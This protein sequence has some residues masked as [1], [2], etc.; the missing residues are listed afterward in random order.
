LNN[1]EPI[2]SQQDFSNNLPQAIPIKSKLYQE[3][4]F[5][6]PVI[7]FS[8]LLIGKIILLPKDF[9]LFWEKLFSPVDKNDDLSGLFK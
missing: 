7:L 5:V 2:I 6:V 1:P 4:I 8:F 9:K 3:P